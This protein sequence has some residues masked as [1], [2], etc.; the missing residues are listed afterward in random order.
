MREPDEDA[1]AKISEALDVSPEFLTHAFRHTGAIAAD[2]HMRRQKT[3]KVSDWKSTEAKLNLY[4]MRSAFL[5]RRVPL[6]PTNHI[7]TFDPDDTTAADAAKL[8]R[9]QWRMPIGPVHNRTRWIESAGVIVIDEQLGTKRID[10][11]SQWASD[12][13]AMLLNAELAN[14]RKRWT[15]AHELGYLVLH[16]NY[17]DPDVEAQAD[18][19]AAEFLMPRHIIEPDLRDLT[20]S[21]LVALK[22]QWGISMEAIFE[23]AYR[24]GKVTSADRQRF[25]R[26]MNARRW[27]QNEPADD[28]IPSDTPELAHTIGQTLLSKGGLTRDE[29]ARLTGRPRAAGEVVFLPPHTHLRIL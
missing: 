2:A 26:T 3:T 10:G 19:F 8:V 17:I 21:R 28:A 13:P 6:N 27:R 24:L 16:S 20:P 12:Y 5:M 14:D 11:L 23:H 7:P 29:V 1:V 25:Y 18:A 4:R 22:K 9:A 15:L